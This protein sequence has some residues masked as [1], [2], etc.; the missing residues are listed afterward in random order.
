[1]SST[2]PPS[3][4]GSSVFRRVML[5][6][7]GLIAAALACLWIGG[8][9]VLVQADVREW[10]ALEEIQHWVA[11]MAAEE[12]PDVL[13]QELTWDESPIWDPDVLYEVLEEEDFV[14]ALRDAEGDLIAGY[15]GL[16][17][18]LGRSITV[19]EHPE[20]DDELRA[21]THDLAQG[22]FAVAKFRTEREWAIWWVMTNGSLA[23]VLIGLPLAL[24]TGYVLS[25]SVFRRIEMLSAAARRVAEGDLDHRAPVTGEAHEFDRLSEGINRMLDQIQA[26]NANIQSVSVGVAHDLKT[27]LANIGGRLELLRR[28]L[29]DPSAQEAHIEAAEGYLGQVLRIFDALLRLGEVE[30]GQRKRAFGPVDL[31]ALVGDMAETYGPV[32]EDAQKHLARRIAPGL[33]VQGDHELLQQ[34]LSNLLE[35]AV[36]HSRDAARIFVHLDRAGDHIALSVGDDGPG[37]PPT[38]RARIFDRFYRADQSRTRPGNGLGLSLVAAIAQL[39]DVEVTLDPDEEGAVFQVAF[40]VP[41]T[42]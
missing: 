3:L 40:P 7:A 20:I 6:A 39:H 16:W 9:A 38:E 12:G 26:L 41:P 24:G 22:S 2:R 17:P 36:E 1:M 11:D 37:I 30:S 33:Q 28:D 5:S 32:I 27:P 42:A 8:G 31:S 18:D 14:F 13:V 34:M 19:L 35:N 23:L 29:S 10:R 4:L 15:D 25:R 21:V